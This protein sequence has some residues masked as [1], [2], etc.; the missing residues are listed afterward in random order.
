MTMRTLL[1]ALAALLMIPAAS[2]QEWTRFRGPNGTG[3]SKAKNVPVTWTEKD[4]LWKVPVA[5]QSH[6][7]PVIWGERIFLT[8]ASTDG[9]ERMLLC[10]NKA[11][12]TE[13]W[14]KK[15]PMSTHKKHNFNSYA[16]ISPSVDKDRVV[17]GFASPEQYLVRAWD[18]SGKELWSADLGPFIAQHG[19]GASPVLYD[20]RVI[21]CNDQDAESSIVALDAKTGKIAWK[22]AR[23]TSDKAAYATPTILEREGGRTEILTSSFAHGLSS[24]D[25]K[26]GAL[27]WEARVYD[28][29][30]VS[31]PQVAGN[32]ALGTCG[33]GGAGTLYAVRMGGR[34]DVTASHLAYSV[35]PGPYVPTPLVVGERIFLIGDKGVAACVEAATGK[36][37]W[38]ERLEGNFFGSP[39]LIDGKIYV[40]SQEGETVVFAAADQFKVLARNPLGEKCYSTPCVDGDRLYLKTFSHLVCVGPK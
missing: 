3:Y 14:G 15:Y 33:E 11:D 30:A 25:F 21:A 19:V 12:G 22:T 4:F 18:H 28:K 37:V 1:P 5:G 32:I 31:S 6:S 40:N 7:Q 36:E 38:R 13:V 23:R 9:K 39:V 24:L 26:T 34:G 10:L 17:A 35:K 20:D 29:R 16:S 8:T 27:L 2:A